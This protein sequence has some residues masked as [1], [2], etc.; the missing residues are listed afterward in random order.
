MSPCSCQR[1]NWCFLYFCV[2]VSCKH[3]Q[4]TSALENCSKRLD[5]AVCKYLVRLT[6]LCL[7]YC[8]YL[9]V[10]SWNVSSFWRSEFS[11]SLKTQWLF[12]AFK[13]N[14]VWAKD[15]GP[16][17]IRGFWTNVKRILMVTKSSSRGIWWT[18]SQVYYYSSIKN[19]V[20][21]CLTVIK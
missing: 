8:S 19:L 21:F 3:H 20:L 1:N 7:F 11:F 12:F 17:I 15:F 10:S 6:P 2:F 4:E 13:T 5:I 14:Q 9:L 18:S 16:S